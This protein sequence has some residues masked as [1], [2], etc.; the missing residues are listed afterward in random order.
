MARAQNARDSLAAP[1]EEAS[2]DAH[3]D[4]E[5]SRGTQR[6]FDSRNFPSRMIPRLFAVAIASMR[7]GDGEVVAHGNVSNGDFFVS[8]KPTGDRFSARGTR[9]SN[10]QNNN[11][12]RHAPPVRPA[13]SP[14]TS[15][16]P[17]QMLATRMA[18]T[19]SAEQLHI[20]QQA[21]TLGHAVRQRTMRHLLSTLP[22]RQP[23]TVTL[24]HRPS[25]RARRL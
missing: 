17:V 5:T 12:A 15:T 8:Y 19:V 11:R 6:G 9:A 22:S 14:R 16:R 24:P 3:A 1:V 13:G 18:I 10:K 20:D 7:R 2:H 25:T 23:R 4:D 21:V